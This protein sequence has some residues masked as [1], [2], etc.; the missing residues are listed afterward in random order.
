MSPQRTRFTCARNGSGK[1]LPAAD[2]HEGQIGRSAL[3]VANLI[4]RKEREFPCA[5][6]GNERTGQTRVQQTEFGIASSERKRL[7][8][9]LRCVREALLNHNHEPIRR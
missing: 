8:G 7:H 3:W 5:L 6:H 9:F 1:N 4:E 2:A